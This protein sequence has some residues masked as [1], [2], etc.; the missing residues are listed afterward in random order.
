[1]MKTLENFETLEFRSKYPSVYVVGFKSADTFTPFYVGETG[2]LTCRCA[3]YIRAQ[4]K[5]PT[6]FR[7]GTAIKCLEARGYA[8]FLKFRLSSEDRKERLREE[9][10]LAKELEGSGYSL[11]NRLPSFSYHT[12]DKEEE[13]AKIVEFVESLVKAREA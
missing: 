6:D 4:F 7:V 1:M 11:L 13:A 9:D 12:A 5:A 10:V 3:D 8:V 2:N